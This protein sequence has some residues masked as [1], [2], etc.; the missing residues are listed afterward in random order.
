MAVSLTRGRGLLYSA[1]TLSTAVFFALLPFIFQGLD[2]TDTGMSLSVQVEA[3]RSHVDLERIFPLIYLSDFFGGMWLSVINRPSL[4]WARIGGILLYSAN[5]AIVFSIVSG[6][7][8]RER[9]FLVVFVSSF[10]LTM[11]YGIDIINYN[12]L[13]AF[14]L[15]VE[16]WLFHK[17][18]AAPE[19]SAKSHLLG[20]LMGLLSLPVILSRVSLATV[21]ICPVV[22]MVVAFLIKRHRIG[23]AVRFLMF[24]SL[25]FMISAA[26]MGLLY[27]Q[28]GLLEHG[29]VD[30]LA[31]PI[32][33]LTAKG[34]H[35]S[36]DSLVSLYK[37][38]IS[39]LTSSSIHFM[40]MTAI[41]LAAGPFMPRN[42]AAAA[43]V[44]IPV[45]FVAVKLF[46]LTGWPYQLVAYKSIM[47]AAGAST[48]LSALFLILDRGKSTNLV[49]LLAAG[50][51]IMVLT[52]LG[53]NRGLLNLNF[54][55][56]LI[57]PL[58]FLCMTQWLE[59]TGNASLSIVLTYCNSMLAVAML[60]SLYFH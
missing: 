47:T 56:W 13:P 14:L 49:F 19:D 8:R 16:L 58:S 32:E 51:L 23:R 15:T 55:M 37:A 34:A 35:H 30:F 20:F 42:L 5:A 44:L 41:L 3:F 43:F 45:I 6:Y 52:P 10:F 1:Y 38:H 53:S 11:R 22:L 7:F 31:R 57:M 17:A 33:A 9:A 60:L 59:G 36:P 25:G 18:L 26:V 24:S 27:W 12:T 21:V 40:V 2:V 46:Q 54:G 39:M 4:L 48:I 28:I 29:P 50:L